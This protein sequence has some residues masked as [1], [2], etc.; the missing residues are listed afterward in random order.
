MIDR[1]RR[2]ARGH[3]RQRRY[4]PVGITFHWLVAALVLFQLGWGWRIGRL[5][6]GPEKLDAY[7][8]HVQLGLA[9]LLIT[10]L[11][12]AWRIMVPGPIN[13]ADK[14]GWQST[15]AHAT[16]YTF[17]ACLVGLPLSGWAMLS[18]TA[19]DQPLT[20]LGLPWP[21]LP[22]HELALATRW[23]IEAW[24]EWIHFGF[25]GVLVLLIPAHAGAALHH[26]FIH[27]HDVLE[28][29]APGLTA[30]EETL[31]PGPPRRRRPRRSPRPS[32]AG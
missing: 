11:R 8:L 24:A 22:F 4:S 6:V 9:I 19:S 21:F 7:H 29:M 16:H 17:Y 31:R 14:P 12:M 5:P 30:L 3:T 15:A 27:R 25:V 26:H 28:A 18:A 32:A 10:L 20:L 1:L 23:S 13:D 2:W